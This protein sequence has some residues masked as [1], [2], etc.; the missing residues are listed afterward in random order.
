M[1]RNALSAKLST[2]VALLRAFTAER[3]PSKRRVPSERVSRPA[4]EVTS[5]YGVAPTFPGFR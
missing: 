1:T 4:V 5:D 2:L 3:L